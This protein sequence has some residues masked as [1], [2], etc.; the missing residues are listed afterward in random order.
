MSQNNEERNERPARP[1][2]PQIDA[3]LRAEMQAAHQEGKR[4]A[5]KEKYERSTVVAFTLLFVLPV[6]VILLSLLLVFPVL[7]RSLNEEPS[8]ATTLRSMDGTIDQR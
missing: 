8:G 2:P 5:N 4:S 7:V 1:A 6:V 3:Q